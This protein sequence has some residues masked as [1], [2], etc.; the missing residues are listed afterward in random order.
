MDKDEKEILESFLSESD[1]ILG[2]LEKNALKL[3]SDPSSKEV[4]DNIFRCVHS[5]KGNS[6]LFGFVGLK[7]FTHSMENL[8]GRIREGEMEAGTDVVNIILKGTDYIKIMFGRLLK[9]LGNVALNP[10]EEEFME[11]INSMLES[12]GAKNSDE[13]LRV[14]LLKFS[15]RAEIKEELGANEPLKNV[16]DII[17]KIAPHLLEDRRGDPC[18]TIFYE[19][20]D[21][22]REYC[23][24]LEVVQEVQMENFS[25]KHALT[26]FG[27]MDRLIKMHMEKGK[28]EP[29]DMLQNLKNDLE[30]LYHEEAGFD[31]VLAAIT[32]ETMKKYREKLTAKKPSAPKKKAAGNGGGKAGAFVSRK[33]RIDQ[34]MLDKAINTAGELVTISEYFNYIQSQIS[35]GKV[36][37]NLGSLRDAI[38]ALQEHSETLSRDLYDIRKVPIKEALEKLP[39][40]VRDTQVSVGKK[41]RL[42]IDGDDN[43]VDKGIIPKLETILVHIIRNSIDHGLE[44]PEERLDAGKPE[45]GTIS[46][47]VKSDESTMMMEISDDGRGLDIGKIKKKLVDEELADA[48]EVQSLSDNAIAEKVFIPGISTA[49]E[50]TETSGRGVGMDIVNSFINE[51][52]GS[53][54]LENRPG[55]GISVFL[56]IPLIQ[57]TLVK[58]GLAVSVGKCVFLIPIESIIE[59]FRPTKSE[60]STIEFKG[61]IVQRRGEILKLIRLKEFFNI[62]S[63]DKNLE[64]VLLVMVQHKSDRV[65]FMVDHI[66]GQRQIIYKDLS[67]K[68]LKTPSPFEGVSVYD[69]SRLAMILDID[70]I[71]RQSE[72]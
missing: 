24:I 33:L 44:T 61:E 14:E 17:R 34:E 72:K 26:V 31:D 12:G 25:E 28:E 41:A 27:N 37:S 57:T 3:E 65:C 7:L 67:V 1:E 36:K 45:E 15:N 71:I 53:V 46:L 30:M 6:G 62:N 50:V 4:V 47:N 10:E 60:I 70:G 32:E 51:M 8:I 13:M 2:D 55:K 11:K 19:D 59:S 5:L 64:D 9:N 39:R 48:D 63:K 56:A 38:L 42:I 18:D 35:E 29:V 22:S 49:T 68:T 66:I 43:L 23:A 20:M 54:R 21:V 69:G 52:G 58:K 16:M 40:V